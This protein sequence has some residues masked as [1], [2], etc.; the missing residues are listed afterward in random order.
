MI[1][2]LSNI[3]IDELLQKDI[4]YIINSML[5]YDLMMHRKENGIKPEL[6]ESCYGD[7]PVIEPAFE[8]GPIFGR[9][10]LNFI[11]ISADTTYS[12]II[13][14]NWRN[15]DLRIMCLG[16]SFSPCDTNHQVIISNKDHILVML[17][18]ADKCI[19]HLTTVK[20]QETD[21]HHL[22]PAKIA[23]YKLVIEHL[24]G[25]NQD[26]IWWTTQGPK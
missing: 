5:A 20:S 11:G 18:L 26:K 4:P 3:Q 17:K 12:N 19:A 25:L 16:S 13:R 7:S 22:R 1:P 24:H 10:L 8:L 6:K 14:K 9:V 21:H 15:S 23:T 2:I